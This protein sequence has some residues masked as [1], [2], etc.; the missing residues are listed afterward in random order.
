MSQYADGGVMTSKPYIASGKY[1]ER[2]SGGQYCA[3]CRYRPGLGQGPEA[4]PFTTL[5]WDFLLRHRERFANHQRIG[6]QVRNLSRLSEQ[7]AEAIRTQ[8]AAIRAELE[9]AGGYTP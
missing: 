7:Q 6:A 5:Y 9:Q 2:M 3:R 1:I 4:C 8:A